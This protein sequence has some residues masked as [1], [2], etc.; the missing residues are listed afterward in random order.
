MQAPPPPP[1]PPPPPDRFAPDDDFAKDAYKVLETPGLTAPVAVNRVQPRYTSDAMRA[2]IQGMVYVQIV[3]DAQ[4][5]VEKA[6]V[7]R[8]LDPQL[9]EQ[10]LEAARL[11]TFKPGMLDGR[12]VPVAAVLMLEFRLH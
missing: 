12:A 9:D 5:S 2:K 8:G 4:G 11:W 10:A 3:I 7:I 6:R 1:P